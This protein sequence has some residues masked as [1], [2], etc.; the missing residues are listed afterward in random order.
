[1]A[2]NTTAQLLPKGPWPPTELTSGAGRATTPFHTNRRP[3]L[4]L[5]A[6]P[7]ALP[8]LLFT[9]VGVAAALCAETC[10]SA[11]GRAGSG[12]LP[13][14]R[15]ARFRDS[16]FKPPAVALA[17]PRPRRRL[18]RELPAPGGCL[19]CPGVSR[20]QQTRR[21]RRDLRLRCEPAPG[22]SPRDGLLVRWGRV[23]WD[24]V[25]SGR[26]G[27]VRLGCVGIGSSL[28]WQGAHRESPRA[29]LGPALSWLRP[30]LWR[31][32]LAGGH[33]RTPFG[34]PG[35]VLP[36][37][38]V[39]VASRTEPW[40]AAPERGGSHPPG[41]G[42]RHRVPLGHPFPRQ[43]KPSALPLSSAA[44]GQTQRAPRLAGAGGE[45]AT[46]AGGGGVPRIPW[47]GTRGHGGFLR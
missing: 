6:L 43:K 28:S 4:W 19:R 38:R 46:G 11:A 5:P 27:S 18:S 15:A 47:G 33:G 24:R 10:R 2:T 3:R 39:A 32:S 35:A 42:G 9:G 36:S 12:Q 29:G 45:T 13:S 17:T 44:G 7:A 8:R 41:A 21:V 34:C 23:R 25:S 40:G 16:A 1:M 20:P 37:Q 26:L 22:S 30:P 31:G 14:G